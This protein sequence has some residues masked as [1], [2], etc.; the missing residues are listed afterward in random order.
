[1]T[2]RAIVVLGFALAAC[3]RV[4]FD[5]L[6][7]QADASAPED[8]SVAPDADAGAIDNE[9]LRCYASEDP[10]GENASWWCVAG[11]PSEL[12]T[13]AADR[14]L[15]IVQLELEPP[16]KASRV[17]A[18]LVPNDGLYRTW[19]WKLDRTRNENGATL[20]AG[21]S[22]TGAHAVDVE[23]F[24]EREGDPT[25]EMAAAFTSRAYGCARYPYGS[26]G[27]SL[28][29][30]QAWI[31][32]FNAGRFQLTNI[33]PLF[34][35]GVER[36]H[37]L[38]HGTGSSTVVVGVHRRDLETMISGEQTV[39]RAF[40][41]I[42]DADHFDA[43]IGARG[44][45][46][47]ASFWVHDQSEAELAAMTAST[48]SARVAKI[49]VYTDRESGERRFAALF[50][51]GSSTGRSLADRAAESARVASMLSGAAAGGAEVGV[52]LKEWKG[53]NQLDFNARRPFRAKNMLSPFL[54]ANLINEVEAGAFELTLPI[55]IPAR[56]CATSTAVARTEPLREALMG[57]I[58]G[59]VDRATAVVDRFGL[60]ALKNRA[61]PFSM[62]QTI[63]RAPPGCD[64][65]RVFS[66]TTLLDQ[67]MFYEY[68][69][70]CVLNATHAETLRTW[71]PGRRAGLDPEAF[72]AVLD[73]AMRDEATRA[74]LS[75]AGRDE[76]LEQAQIIYASSTLSEPGTV[77]RA[78]AGRFRAPR[79]RDAVIDD[80]HVYFFGFFMEGEADP[81]AVEAA[82]EAVMREVLLPP[83]RRGISSGGTA[84][85]DG[86]RRGD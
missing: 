27:T 8:A 18:V 19:S 30:I 45:G 16:I 40:H 46:E 81:A 75:A 20:Y 5:A 59:D 76:A 64:D 54:A 70:H 63:L 15:A 42:G 9:E 49:D 48:K 17:A 7:F 47:P 62:P 86:V 69:L 73:T 10:R 13:F 58:A 28:P 14:D 36:R 61:L 22:G 6:S 37:L 31:E 43:A 56:A 33:E 12:D 82:L 1:M 23:P 67:A 55:D 72:D 50:V 32:Q 11:T 65:A 71:M 79:C 41:S 66:E 38:F 39:L 83:L 53:E 35:D 25:D 34:V 24:R 84:C 80:F 68:A 4:D 3:P 60:E 26:S 74:G 52:Y 77:R 85:F 2:R 51:A 78:V 57:M 21:L 44:L 29:Q